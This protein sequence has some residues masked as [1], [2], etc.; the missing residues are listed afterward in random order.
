MKY[1]IV[2][3]GSIG[4]RHLNNLLALGEKDVF[5]C[6][7]HHST[8]L[9]A[10]IKDIPVET[11][12]EA[13]L[14][15]SPDGV[16][17]ANPTALH[18]QTAIP[19]AEAGS[20]ILMEKP[21]SDGMEG[22]DELKAALKKGG[23]RFLTGFQ[24]RF[25]PGLQ[26]IDCWLKQNKVGAVVSAQVCWGEYLPGWH[27]WEDYRQ[28]YAAR[29]DL[30]GGVVNTLC[31]PLDYLRWL[32]GDVSALSATTSNFGLGLDVEDTADITLQFAS[33]AQGSFHLDYLQQPGEHTLKIVGT[34]GMITWDNASTIARCYTAADKHWEEVQPPAGFERNV[35][36]LDETRHFIEVTQGKAAPLCTLDDGLAALELT[37]AINRSSQDGFLVK[38]TR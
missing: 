24:F 8:L 5:L 9:D 14:A 27:P 38:F 11:S 37:Q 25:N 21:I 31:H 34:E 28:S 36:F 1:L 6:R 2:G 20:S 4:R 16:V 19:A 7:S 30:G 17:I 12:M 22:I 10:E 18:L 32:L 15:H 35:M 26:Q 13:A 3:Y 29:A 23:G 33:G